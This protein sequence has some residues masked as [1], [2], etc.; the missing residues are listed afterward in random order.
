[1][2]AIVTLPALAVSL[3]CVYFSRPLGFAAIAM[4]PLAGAELDVLLEFVVDPEVGALAPSSRLTGSR[5]AAYTLGTR[6]A[7]YRLLAADRPTI[8]GD[9]HARH[10]TSRGHLGPARARL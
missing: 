1:V 7:A 5:M 8:R 10:Q 9:S 6:R 2:N 4:V 3:L